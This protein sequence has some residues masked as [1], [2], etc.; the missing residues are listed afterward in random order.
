[1]KTYGDKR[2]VAGIDLQ[3]RAGSC[4]GL[5]GPNGAGK[6]TTVEMLEGLHPPTAGS[7][8][9][10]GR[11]WGAGQDQELRERIG[12]QLQDTQLADKLHVDE[13]LT[14]FRSFYPNGK[15]TEDLLQLLDLQQERHQQ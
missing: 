1:M 4:F 14:L 11:G 3:V 9:L 15:S 12:V 5:L 8:R 7:I 10:F 2:A 13:V 6:T